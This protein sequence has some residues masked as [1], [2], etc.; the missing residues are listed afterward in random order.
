[1]KVGV[2]TFHKCINYGSYWQA[3][4]MVEAL[5]ARGHEAELLDHDCRC[6]RRAEVRCALQPKLPERTPR[7]ELGI[8]ASKTRRF[9]EAISALPLS[10]R[11]SLHEPEVMDEYDAVVVGSDEVWNFRH[12]WYGSKPI[13]WGDGVKAQRLVS[14]AA[15]F[16]N[17][18]AW[19]GI[20]PAWARRL[21]RFSSISVRDQNSWHLVRGGTHRDPELV[22]DPCLL[23]PEP[24]QQ[25][26]KA[27]PPY[28]LV[29]GYDFPA[30]LKRLARRW[31]YAAGVRL[32]SVGYSNDFAHE[33]RIDD[34]PVEFAELVSGASAVITNFFH[35]CVFSLLHGKPWATAP[36]DYRS[37]KIPDL[38]TTVGAEHRLL[39]CE[40]DDGRFAEL[41]ETPMQPAVELRMSELRAR[42]EAYLDAALT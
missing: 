37:I 32:V 24:A 11:F 25:K 15:S 14:Y 7:H 42:S 36:S 3:R 5:R 13:F 28:A 39:D 9:V 17:H 1:M 6:V 40:T 26:A 38:A 16:G 12:P 20:H 8:Y 29:Y 23:F 10:K 19:D 31:S 18:S 33:Q 41:M 35:G 30:W 4:C 21:G 27:G 22:L 2:L 34:G